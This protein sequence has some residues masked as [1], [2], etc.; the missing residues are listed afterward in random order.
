VS[1]ALTGRPPT[2]TFELPFSGTATSDDTVIEGEVA[3][4][5]GRVW[6]A[7]IVPADDGAWLRSRVQLPPG[8]YP[9]TLHF[10]GRHMGSGLTLIVG[11]DYDLTVIRTES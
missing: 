8:S 5:E 6:P 2:S 4:G 9:M 1:A 10:H 7:R 11:A 3:F